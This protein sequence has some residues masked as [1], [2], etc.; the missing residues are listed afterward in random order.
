MPAKLCLTLSG[1]IAPV[2]LDCYI[3]DPDGYI[4]EVGRSGNLVWG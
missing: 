4:I 3:R 2:L 1:V